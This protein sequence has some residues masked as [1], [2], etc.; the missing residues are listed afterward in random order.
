MK[1]KLA[2]VLSAG[3]VL[4]SVTGISVPVMA[5]DD[6]TEITFWHSMDRGYGETL[7]KQIEE[8]NDTIGKEKKIKVSAV[9]QN[10]PG[11]EALSAAMSSDDYENMPD[12][13]QLYSESV[14]LVRDYDRTVWTEDL[15]DDDSS[16]KKEDLVPNI[17]KSF[18]IDNKMI[19]MPYNIAGYLLY[20][21]K[22][23][24][25]EAGYEEPPK[26]LAEMAEMLP[27]LV[28]KTDADYGL[29]V[30]INM[31]ELINF[32]E[33]EG[34]NGSY[35]GDN[36]NG[37]SGF[38]TKL[39]CAEDDTLKD[40][41]TAWGDIINTGAYKSLRDSINEEFAAEMHSMVIMSSSRLKTIE[42]LVGD[43]FDW[44]VAAVPT[45]HEGDATGSYPTG[46]GLFIMNREDDAKVKAAWEFVQYM[47]SP[48]VQA[49]WTETTGY[50]PVN[51][52]ALETDT[53]KKAVEEDPKLA[54]PY[55]LISSA[56]ETVTS[57][58]VPNYSEVD[59]LIKDTMIAYAD[60]ST[61]ADGAYTAITDGVKSIFEDYYRANPIE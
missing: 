50:V 26:T 2:A 31:N 48:E 52:K 15:F 61:D 13:I 14:S 34:E 3:M 12:V 16:V 1:R 30:R 55:E 4:A 25:K 17:A 46:S 45:V 28:D 21:N 56:P 8:F 9:F 39:A 19:G 29:N 57:P 47:A 10:Y 49:E 36:E 37:H 20:Y 59:T 7:D 58:F 53:Y 60:G 35:F 24:L 44:G 33:T 11:T 5:D 22:D 42:D 27:N 32:I 43:A 54:V 6:Y 18:E 41:I 23:Q 40:F 51:E 38:M